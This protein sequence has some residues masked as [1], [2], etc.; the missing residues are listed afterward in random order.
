MYLDYLS[1]ASQSASQ[2]VGPGYLSFYSEVGFQQSVQE[3]LN[4]HQNFRH[5][6]IFCI[7]EELTRC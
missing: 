5:D 6:V 2:L 3:W 1:G 7:V 4:L